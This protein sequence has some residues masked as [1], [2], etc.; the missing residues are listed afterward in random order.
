MNTEPGTRA[1]L[2]HLACSSRATW[3]L[4]ELL[5]HFRE[6]AFGLFLLLSVLPAFLP[7]PAGAGAVSG[8]LV[9]WAGLQMLFLADHPWL[10][11]W[12]QRRPV[13]TASIDRFRKRLARPLAWIERFSK[14]RWS[15]L[16]DHRAI[17]MCTGLLLVVLGLLLALPLP[18]TNY[19]FGL[20]LVVFA[21]ALIERDGRTLAVA[22]ALGALQ[23]LLVA[24]LFDQVLAAASGLLKLVTGG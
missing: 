17:R 10:P 4:G 6:R 1:L 7:L 8:P 11:A 24:L 20:I 21:V 18:L 2:D 19:P 13:A 15:A 14:P 23:L 9:M 5:D 12:L 22:W 3:P 16:L